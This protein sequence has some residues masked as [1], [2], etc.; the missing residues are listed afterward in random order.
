M[1]QRNTTLKF[2]HKY[3]SL[4]LSFYI[5]ISSTRLVV[6]QG[7]WLHV[8]AVRITVETMPSNNFLYSF[9]ENCEEQNIF[10]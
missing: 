7:G 3:F 6:V 9:H 1:I 10:K 5:I 2:F 8:L 4:F